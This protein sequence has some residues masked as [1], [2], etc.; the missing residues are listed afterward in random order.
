MAA[1]Q[2]AFNGARKMR[3]APIVSLLL[4][5]IVGIIAV[6]FGRGWLNNEADATATPAVILQE[7]ET[8]KILVSDITIERGDLLTDEAFRVVDWPAAHIPD[9][10]ITEI[11][12]ILNQQGGYPYALGVMVPGEPLLSA[13]LSH[14]AVRDTLA[15]IIEPGF[16]AVSVEVSD[17]SGVAGFVL[18]DHRVDVNVFSER[19]NP[20]TGETIH[21]VKTLLE[22][23]RVLAIDQSFQENLEGAAP[24]RTVTLQVTPEQSKKL[25]LA[26]QTSEIGLV[27]RPE[28]EVTL[29]TPK[30]KPKRSVA[31]APAR[32][33]PSKPSLVDIRV[34]Q[35][36]EEE[37]V[38]APNA[39]GNTQNGGPKQ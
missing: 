32:A 9:G 27:L 24:A 22:D 26:G 13:K 1:A 20:S 5:I 36:E 6:V 3:I 38:T 35:G 17:A 31:R 23:V 30:P 29:A 10:A 25:G 15:A 28:D 21:E 37:I 33:V 7:I 18:P 39:Q 8:Q 4:S 12:A 14:S 2:A 19:R 34:I 16:R 11:S